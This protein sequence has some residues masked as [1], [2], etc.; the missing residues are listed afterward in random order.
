MPLLSIHPQAMLAAE[1]AREAH[2]QGKFWEYHD[3]LYQNQKALERA[4]LERYAEQVGL[5]MTRFRQALDTHKHQ[6]AVRRDMA[7]GSRAGV[8]GTPTIFINDRLYQGPRGFPPEGLEAV[9][10][11][12]FGL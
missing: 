6:A 12:Y 9:S 3:I 7:E 5:D 10:A 11:A 1:A 2:E 8:R 4:D